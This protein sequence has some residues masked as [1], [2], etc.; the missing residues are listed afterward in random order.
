MN[1][2]K[3]SLYREKA[4]FYARDASASTCFGDFLGYSVDFAYAD[5]ETPS[6][7]DSTAF[8]AEKC[9]EGIKT[10]DAFVVVVVVVSWSTFACIVRDQR[11]ATDAIAE[12]YG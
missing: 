5:E 6:C 8:A 7:L 12:N 10:D 4:T 1:N 11:Y 3:P 9:D 2:L